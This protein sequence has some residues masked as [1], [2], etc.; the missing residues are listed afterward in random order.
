MACK[1]E[2]FQFRISPTMTATVFFRPAKGQRW[3]QEVTQKDVQKLIEK[4]SAEME[5]LPLEWIP[6]PRDEDPE[7]NED[8]V[9]DEDDE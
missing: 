3:D 9:D 7:D 4:L 8:K 5:C 6:P 1:L 2:E